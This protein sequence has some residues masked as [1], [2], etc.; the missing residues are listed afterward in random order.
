MLEGGLKTFPYREFPL[1]Y[2]APP[3][4]EAAIAPEALRYR[5]SINIYTGNLEKYLIFSSAGSTMEKNQ[6]GRKPHYELYSLHL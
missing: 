4:G 2:S 1:F 3:I 5:H 6:T